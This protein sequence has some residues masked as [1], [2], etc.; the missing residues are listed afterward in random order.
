M[1]IF[2][3]SR[4]AHHR[5]ACN[6][7]YITNH[8]HGRC[9]EGSGGKILISLLPEETKKHTTLGFEVTEG[10]LQPSPQTGKCP[11]K[12]A[13]GLCKVHNT[14]LKPFGC[15]A[16]P[17]TLN[18]NSTLILRYRYSRLKCHGQGKLAFKVFRPS[19]NLIFGNIEAVRICAILDAGPREK[20]PALMPL[21]SFQNL[22]YLDELKHH[23]GQ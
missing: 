14:D 17:F 7:D 11:H 21:Q 10:F 18:K 20:V 12:A 15:I 1:P 13:N 3:S 2:V 23:P 5:F 22:K 16:S 4:W 9:Y 6:L 8:C 19:L